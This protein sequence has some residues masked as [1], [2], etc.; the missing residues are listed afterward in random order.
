MN[1]LLKPFVFILLSSPLYAIVQQPTDTGAGVVLLENYRPQVGVAQPA[2][3]LFRKTNNKY[4]DGGGRRTQQE[5]L[6]A[7]AARELKEESLNTFRLN[8][9]TLNDNDA[10]KLHNTYGCYFKFVS[11]PVDQRGNTPI[12]SAYYT[13]NHQLLSR[14]QGVPHDWKETNGMTRVFINQ[15]SQDGIAQNRGDLVT[16]DVYGNR[17]TIEGRTAGCIRDAFNQGILANVLATG[18]ATLRENT[19]FRGGTKPFL[20]GTKCYWN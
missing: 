11:G 4:T 13:H 7:T 20:I 5:D 6:R 8:Y 10:V 1:N 15:L 3:I 18:P 16:T 17:I 14:I 12:Y 9:L 2:V 19:N